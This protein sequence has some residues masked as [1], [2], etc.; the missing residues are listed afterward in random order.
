MKSDSQQLIACVVIGIVQF[1]SLGFFKAVLLDLPK[2]IS[3]LEILI[4]GSAVVAISYSIGVGLH[5]G[6][7]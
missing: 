5:V 3:G 2:I 7:G 6:A 4:G 1:F